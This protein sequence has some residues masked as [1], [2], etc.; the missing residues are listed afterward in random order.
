MGFPICI[1][2]SARLATRRRVS[3][4][5]F[6]YC[7]LKRPFHSKSLYRWPL[8]ILAARLSPT[9]TPLLNRMMGVNMKKRW[10]RAILQRNVAEADPRKPNLL[11]NAPYAQRLSRAFQCCRATSSQH[12]QKTLSSNIHVHSALKRSQT[13]LN[14]QS[15]SALTQHSAPFSVRTVTRPTKPPQSCATT[16]A[17]TLVKNLLYARNVVRPLCKLYA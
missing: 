4:S 5:P 1:K 8:L 11:L 15:T 14:S 6:V 2:L 9:S 16:A 13:R 12:I 17:R 7:E 3:N 10:R